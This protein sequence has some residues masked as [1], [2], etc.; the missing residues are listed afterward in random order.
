MSSKIVT[1]NGNKVFE[2]GGKTVVPAAFLSFRPTPA[3]VSLFYRNGVRLFQMRV[4][5]RK[6]T[7]NMN[8]SNYGGVWVGD[9]Q[10][11]F[12]AFDRQMEMFMK[13]A[14]E[15]YFMPAVQLDMPEW[16]IAENECPYDSYA[17]LCE[18]T[19]EEKWIRDASDY[20]QAFIKYAEEKYGDRIFAYVFAG[21][22]SNEWLDDLGNAHKISDR[23]AADYRK[24]VG[25]PN[26][27]IPTKEQMRSVELPS[28]RG[29]D[30]PVYKF[31]KYTSEL[32][33]NL[34]VRF[35]AAAQEVLNHEK[36]IGFFCGYANMPAAWQNRTATNGYEKVWACGDVD[37][38]F[39]PSA[40]LCRNFEDASSF[41]VMA[42]SI[43]INNKLYVHEIDHHTYLSKYPSENFKI[44]DCI[45]DDEP[46][47]IS[48]IRREVCAAASK[49]EALYW[50]DMQGGWYA[51]PGLEAE[52]QNEI[53]VL[54]ELYKM[55]HRSVSEIAVFIDPMSHYRMHDQSKMTMDCA[56][57]NRDKLHHC[58]APFDFLNLRDITK[59]DLSRYKMLVFLNAIEMTDEV[60]ACLAEKAQDITKVW[61]YAPNHATGGISEVCPI[62]LQEIDETDLKVQ[63]RE[64]LFGFSSPATLYAVD[65]KDSEILACYTNGTPA[66]AR[67][68]KD[69][70][71]AVGN[72]PTDLW[73]DLA[74]EA[75]VHIYSDTP[76]AFYADSRFV[77]RQSA[78]ETDLTI[79]MPFDCVLE[80]M[81]D[82]G[83]YKTENKDL[84]YNAEKGST[85][86]FIIR[87]II[88]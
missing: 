80:E 71:L 18:A 15:G 76:G 10:Y 86:L 37:M 42:D 72:V 34:I 20:M 6:N 23:R 69:V 54:N 63:Y 35:A 59:I 51:S 52:L 31:Q 73:R 84:K 74:R 28:L 68:G 2:I 11:D 77:A 87:E 19:F 29:D 45:Y 13:F 39:A 8:Y 88:E 57:N 3:N 25:D 40:Y 70:Y 53:N 65:D 75:G 33:P 85:K 26:A 5:G 22:R 66:C 81:F 21:G 67:K 7:W 9:H 41:Q 12:A 55:P 14:P 58:G 78:W 38:I 1:K 16:W 17:Y 44:M 30:D 56:L 61:L 46:T 62:K 43:G 36:P 83:I 4:S 79:H 64:H 27:E 48:V 32:I 24:K 50:F 60:K 47:T 82:G 49:G